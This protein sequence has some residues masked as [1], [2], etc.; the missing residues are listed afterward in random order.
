MTAGVGTRPRGDNRGQQFGVGGPK[1]L[2]GHGNRVLT[3]QGPAGGF[4]RPGAKSRGSM[5]IR[6]GGTAKINT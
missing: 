1:G 5:G 2:A 4:G 6:N 3:S